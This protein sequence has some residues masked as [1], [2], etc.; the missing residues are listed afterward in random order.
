M[1]PRIEGRNWVESSS[2]EKKLKT[3]FS[4]GILGEVKATQL[5]DE[6]KKAQI[7]GC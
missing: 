1:T 5:G 2:T 7:L 6:K 3:P 4:P